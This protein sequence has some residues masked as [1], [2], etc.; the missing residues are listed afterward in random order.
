MRQWPRTVGEAPRQIFFRDICLNC[1]S[2]HW[3]ISDYA[4]DDAGGLYMTSWPIAKALFVIHM[5]RLCIFYM[6]SPFQW[7]AG[8]LIFRYS[9]G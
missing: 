8:G 1:V 4:N 2:T 6:R 5:A 9:S 3:G 7:Q